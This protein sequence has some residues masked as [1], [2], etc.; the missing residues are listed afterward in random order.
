MRLLIIRHGIAEDFGPDGTDAGRRLTAE[1]VDKTRQVAK[2]LVK[3]ARKPEVVLSSPKVRALQTAKIVGEAFGAA[4]RVEDVIQEE[5]PGALVNLMAQCNEESIAIVGHEPTLGALVEL[6]ISGRMS[7]GST[8]LKKAGVACFELNFGKN[9]SDFDAQ[10]K[11]FAG[12]EM[13]AM[14]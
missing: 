5:D 10:L 6:L 7:K 3:I 1:G 13:L 11:W 4:V 12:P 14:V 2:G 8:P 9:P